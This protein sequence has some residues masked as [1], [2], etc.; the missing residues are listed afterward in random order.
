MLRFKLITSTK[1][2]KKRPNKLSL[3]MGNKARAY[4]DKT[5]K[6]LFG[7]SGNICAFPDCNKQLVNQMNAKNSNIC[8][9]EAANKGGE[10]YRAD[11]TD[12]ERAD[13]PNLIL[14][15][16][17]HHDETNNVSKYSVKKLQ[18]MKSNHETDILNKTLSNNPSM[19][20]NTINAIANINIDNI[21]D[22]GNLIVINPNDK[23]H[24]NAVKRNTA[25]IQEYKVYRGKVNALYNELEA[26]GS[27]KKEKLL[28]NIKQIYLRV[29]GEY[30]QDSTNILDIIRKNSD[31]IYDDVYNVLYDKSKDSVYWKEDLALGI[32][33]IMV[34]S[35]IRC[36]ILEEPQ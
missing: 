16:I 20:A 14:L 7:L 2:F 32:Q 13:Y 36:K 1:A 33:L 28:S 10:R 21:I 6:R 26:Q 34:D 5:L 11:M 27:I 12:E 3:I 8:H 4:T 18:E 24:Y 30:I 31:N 15:C 19:L 29:K 35:F 23:L 25:I 9:I 17:Q 22:S